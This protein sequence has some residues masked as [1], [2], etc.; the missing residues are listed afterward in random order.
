MKEWVP[1]DASWKSGD[2]GGEKAAYLQ[3]QVNEARELLENVHPSARID[4]LEEYRAWVK[5]RNDWLER[6]KETK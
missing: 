1:I 5:K 4:T 6:N 2:V 3:G